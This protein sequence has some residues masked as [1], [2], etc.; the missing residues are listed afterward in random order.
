ME[1]YSVTDI[2][3]KRS[4]NEDYYGEVIREDFSVFI[5]ADGMGGHNAGEVASQKAVEEIEE[6]FN[7]IESLSSQVLVNIQKSIDKANLKIFEMASEDEELNNMGT[8]VVIAVIYEDDLFVGN[9]GDSRCYLLSSYGFRQIS[10][11]HSLI[12]EMISLG[13]L[14]EEEADQLNQRNI[15]TKSV[16]T[17]ESVEANMIKVSLEEGDL[18]L[19]C[20]DGLDSHLYDEEIEEILRENKPIDYK[21]EKLIYLA[22]ELGG[23]DNITVTLVEMGE[24]AHE[25]DR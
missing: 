1:F 24:K 25:S 17:N 20:T 6:Y 10:R 16:G 7:E 8:T 13:S 12:N 21:V 22:N 23:S 19:L 15:I 5:V 14:S 18:I 9:V 4:L 2:G 3:Q 11:D